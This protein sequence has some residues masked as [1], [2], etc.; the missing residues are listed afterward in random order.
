MNLSKKSKI[1][2]LV[3]TAGLLFGLGTYNYVMKGP[4]SIEFKKA[5]FTG[6]AK[7][8]VVAVRKNPLKWTNKIIILEGKVTFRN[9]KSLT[10]N[11]QVF[12]QYKKDEP[13]VGL[14]KI[15]KIK[16]RFIGY[17]D[18]MDDLRLDQCIFQN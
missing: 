3:I 18:L 6:T 8:F 14:T 17:D 9:T 7:E 5:D 1:I 13:Y 11:S 12:C 15:L 16:G 10:F 4:E 2:I